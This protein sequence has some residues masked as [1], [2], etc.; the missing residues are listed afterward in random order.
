MEL[1]IS[2]DMSDSGESILTSVLKHL[3]LK[4]HVCLYLFFCETPHTQTIELG[5]TVLTQPLAAQYFR[6]THY[7]K[8]VIVVYAGL[9]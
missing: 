1:N 8:K 2:T 3:H 7:Y 4:F 6:V 9:G 5:C